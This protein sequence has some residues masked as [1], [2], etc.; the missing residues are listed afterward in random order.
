MRGRLTEQSEELRSELELAEQR[1]EEL[2]SMK[3]E[4]EASEN[5]LRSLQGLPSD[6]IIRPPCKGEVKY[7]FTGAPLFCKRLL[8]RMASA[9]P[10]GQQGPIN[11]KQQYRSWWV[12]GRSHL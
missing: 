4:L 3:G 9:A 12:H 8:D 10:T 11:I 5:E 1:A 7:T 2:A 6:R